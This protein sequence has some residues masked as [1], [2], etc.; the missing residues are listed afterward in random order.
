MDSLGTP[1]LED[2][3]NPWTAVRKV[4]TEGKNEYGQL[5]FIYPLWIYMNL[6]FE[7]L[8]HFTLDCHYKKLFSAIGLYASLEAL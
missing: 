2:L 3:D 8:L 7:G 1:E 6:Y 4:P 5:N